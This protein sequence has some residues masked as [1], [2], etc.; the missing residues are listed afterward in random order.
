MHKI[1]SIPARSKA[2]HSMYVKLIDEYR[3]SNL[4]KKNFCMLHH[5]KTGDLENWER[6]Y[7][8]YKGQGLEQQEPTFIPVVAEQPVKNISL[9]INDLHTIIIP[10]NFDKNH[11]TKLLTLLVELC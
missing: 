8:V 6:R 10:S 7:A 4:S 1:Y 5:I 2:R 11:F 9:V 3:T